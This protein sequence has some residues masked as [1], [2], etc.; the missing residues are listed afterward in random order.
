MHRHLQS[1]NRIGDARIVG[2]G[3]SLPVIHNANPTL[4]QKRETWE[5][6][7]A[8]YCKEG[9]LPVTASSIDQET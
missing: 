3:P 1:T 8:A 5:E 6:M 4:P 9:F 7:L 2:A